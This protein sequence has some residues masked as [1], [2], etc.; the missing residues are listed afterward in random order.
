MSRPPNPV[1][2]EKRP[3]GVRSLAGY[4]PDFVNEP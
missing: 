3:M 1:I 4:L 2:E